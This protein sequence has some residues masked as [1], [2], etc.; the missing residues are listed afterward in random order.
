MTPTDRDVLEVISAGVLIADMHEIVR[1]A[2]PAAAAQLNRRPADCCGQPLPLLLGMSLPLADHQ[3]SREQPEMRLEIDQ[4]GATLGATIT[5]L[6]HRGYACVF[7]R[8]EEGRG[9]DRQLLRVEREA[10]MI[11]IINSFAHEVRNPLASIQATVD[12]LRGELDHADPRHE[13]LHRI[14]RQI[15]RLAGLAE[16]PLA[17]GRVSSSQRVACEVRALVEAAVAAVATQSTAQAIQIAVAMRDDL[18]RVVVDERDLVEALTELLDNAI[19]ASALGSTVAV[20]HRVIARD[21]GHAPRVVIEIEDAGLGMARGDVVQ[22]L[23]PYYTTKR[24]AAGVGLSLAQRFIQA[25]GGRLAITTRAGVGTILQV[26][27][28]GEEPA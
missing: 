7:R 11:S 1:Y 14:E 20:S 10:A 5:L 27:L 17:L 2:N 16:G 23:R 13:H 12:Y 25:S 8:V 28:P 18:P 3:I 9:A 26:D 6:E 4:D 24:G 22:A 21:R 19:T 15:R